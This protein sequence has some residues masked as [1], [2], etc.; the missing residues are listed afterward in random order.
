VPEAA[1]AVGGEQEGDG[2]QR[3]RGDRQPP[4][5]PIA[6]WPTASARDSAHPASARV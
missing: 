2:Q 6:Q 5:P 3:E 1:V 4:G